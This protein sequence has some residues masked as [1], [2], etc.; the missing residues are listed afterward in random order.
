M[1]NSIDKLDFGD[2]KAV[3]NL[4]M[5]NFE[6]FFLTSL[7]ESFLNVFYNSILAD[8]LSVGVGLY[9]KNE[10]VSFAIGTSKST[11]FYKKILWDNFFGLLVVLIPVFLKK[12]KTIL[13]LLKK[14][15][16]NPGKTYISE[17]AG[18]LLSICTDKDFRK[19][20]ISSR[21]LREFESN[22]SKNKNDAVYLT[23]DATKNEHV[24]HFYRKNG[25]SVVNDFNASKDRK[26]LLFTK[27]L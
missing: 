22:L 19:D 12:P 11:G 4:H 2:V 1:S 25:Y 27:K 5:S 15:S 26:M 24:I 18:W 16:Q 21:V 9:Q 17:K 13:R 10:L 7:G 3:V 14:L 6:G 20:N 8:N 23:T